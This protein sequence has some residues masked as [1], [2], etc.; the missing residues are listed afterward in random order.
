[1]IIVIV[2]L[3]LILIML[4]RI[5]MVIVISHRHRCHTRH[6]FFKYIFCLGDV[7]EGRGMQEMTGVGFEPGLLR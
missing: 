5:S 3:V 2:I 1:M 7:E 4:T 6:L